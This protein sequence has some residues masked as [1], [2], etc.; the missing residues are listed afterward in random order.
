MVIV[1]MQNV[2]TVAMKRHL[3]RSSAITLALL[4][5]PLVLTV[6]NPYAA[7]N[8]GAGG[9]W[10]WGPL[11]FLIMGTL[12]LVV[13]LAIQITLS[14]PLSPA[15]KAGVVIGILFLLALIWVELA[16]DGVSQLF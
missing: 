12:L 2:S 10:D 9:G 16:V 6:L 4:V 8:G 13:N 5:I 15:R 3:V 1:G 7:L 14:F 11:D